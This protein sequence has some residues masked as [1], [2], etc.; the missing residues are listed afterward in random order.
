MSRQQVLS[1]GLFRDKVAFL[2]GA[3]SGIVSATQSFVPMIGQVH[4]GAAEAGIDMLVR[5]LPLEWGAE[6]IRVNSIVPGPIED[7]EG[8]RRLSSTPQLKQAPS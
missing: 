2:A 8:M 4:V 1:P 6:G 3:S 7:T 5:N